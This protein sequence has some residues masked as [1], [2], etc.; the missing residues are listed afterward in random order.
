MFW[1]FRFETGLVELHTLTGATASC[2]TRGTVVKIHVFLTCK[3]NEDKR[4]ASRC[5][6]MTW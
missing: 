1:M 4:S 6:C 3:L 2:A 5:G